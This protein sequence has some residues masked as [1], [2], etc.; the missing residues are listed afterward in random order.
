MPI[1]HQPP[2]TIAGLRS[3][4]WLWPLDDW[5][6]GSITSKDR[7]FAPMVMVRRH[8]PLGAPQSFPESTE[9]KTGMRAIDQ[10]TNGEAHAGRLVSRLAMPP[11]RDF[12][13]RDGDHFQ[14]DEF[15]QTTEGDQRRKESPGRLFGALDESLPEIFKH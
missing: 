9:D 2:A 1:W 12:G 13:I 15:E 14:D 3:G 5:R 7:G 8:S 10:K 4:R 6:G 11:S